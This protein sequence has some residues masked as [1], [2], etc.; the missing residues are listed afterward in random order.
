MADERRDLYEVLEL[1]KGASEEDIKKAYRRLA[2]KYHPD[3]N[4]DNKES[5]KRMKEVNAAY[6]ILSDKEKRARYDQFGHAGVDPSYNP[7][8]AGAGAGGFGG[9]GDI[10]LGDIF[11]SMFGGGFGFG[12]TQQRR[13]GPQQGEHLRVSLQL[14]FEEA[15]FGCEKSVS[16]SRNENCRDCGGTGAQKGTSPETCPVCHGNG[17]VKTTQRTPFGVF[18]TSGPCQNCR[19]TGKIIKTPCETC[20]GTGKTRKSRTIKVKI[21]AGIDDGQTISLRGEGGAGVGGGPEGDLYVT[22]YVKEHPLFKRDGQDVLLEMPVTFVQAALGA[23][24]VVPTIDG[25]VQY[26]MPEGTQTGTIF[27]LR[28]SGIPNIN[29]RGR[30]DQYVKVNVEIPKGLTHDQKELLR[31]FEDTVGDAPYENKKGFFSKVKDLFS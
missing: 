22:V 26:E 6:E 14:T 1:N 16:I 29:G 4:P 25:K 17:Q 20:K 9:F 28:S 31:K 10:D 12:G 5:E 2:K 3:L 7:G 15:A 30:G 24:I 18:A 19:G 27:R 8:G 11:G 21:P 13:N 23:T